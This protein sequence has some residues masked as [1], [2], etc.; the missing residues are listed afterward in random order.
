MHS[1][2][3]AELVTNSFDQFGQEFYAS[4][5][6]FRNLFVWLNVVGRCKLLGLFE[7]S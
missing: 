3:R 7:K 4:L 2:S 6:L 1:F 5:Y